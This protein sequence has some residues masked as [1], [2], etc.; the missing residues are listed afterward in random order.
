MVWAALGLIVLSAVCGA[1]TDL[2]FDAVG[3]AWQMVNCGFTAAYSTCLVHKVQRAADGSLHVIKP[4]FLD[5]LTDGVAFW[6]TRAQLYLR[7]V[8]NTISTVTKSGK[9][10]D[11]FTM[12]Y[13][14][15]LL[16]MPLIMIVIYFFGEFPDV[17]EE[18]RA[19]STAFKR[20]LSNHIQAATVLGSFYR[21]RC[22]IIGEH[23]RNARYPS[24]RNRINK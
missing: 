17:L 18:A 12:A 7:S 11:Q 19:S 10:L 24:E 16:S 14:N 22:D 5:A 9:G 6:V 8:M 1:F 21:T 20:D 2:A 4:Y 15:N 23:F 13:I 3:Y